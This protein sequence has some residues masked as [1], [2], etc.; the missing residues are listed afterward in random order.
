[1]P[2]VAVVG[3]GADLREWDHVVDGVAGSDVAQM[4]GWARLRRLAGF[5]ALHLL[6]REDGRIVGGAQVL[7]RRIPL[8]GRIGYV[9]Y[10]PVVG[11]TG[12]RRA[13]VRRAVCAGLAGL[14]DDHFRMLFVQPGL[15]DDDVAHELRRHGMRPSAAQVAPPASARIDLTR[16][17][18]ALRRGLSSR[19][20]RWTRRWAERGVTVRRATAQDV[21]TVARLLADTGRHQGFAA[22]SAEYL[23]ALD[24]HL[25]RTGH[26][27]TFLGE[28]D[29]R[30]AAVDVLT[31]AGGVAKARLVG[32]DRAGPAAALSVPAAV[33]WEAM[34]WA[35][36]EGHHWFDVGGFGRASADAVLDD[37]HVDVQ[38]LPGPDRYKLRLGAVPF[39]Y[40]TAVERIPSRTVRA[41]YDAVARSDRGR[42]G[43][44]AARR[45]LRG[46]AA[47]R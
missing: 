2:T 13:A 32:L 39:R 42:R 3:A 22:F 34:L 30:P 17:V 37:P 7:H 47:G 25:G 8:F 46:G 15:G 11:V 28:V 43:L 44:D 31:I 9:P 40:P 36:A 35:K 45:R 20:Q 26:A 14:A 12:E 18:E 19:L 23:C 33:R 10:G 16:D 38:A 27:V 24:H 29:G 6:V 21:P 1:M 5:D 41:A 4:S